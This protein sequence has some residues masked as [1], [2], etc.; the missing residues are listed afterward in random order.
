MCSMLLFSGKRHKDRLRRMKSWSP[1][2]LQHY[3]PRVYPYVY[4]QAQPV[5]CPC[6]EQPAPSFNPRSSLA[7]TDA[8]AGQRR[9]RFAVAVLWMDSPMIWRCIRFHS[10]A[11]P[12]AG[13]GA[14]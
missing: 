3:V 6:H 5:G 12:I 13:P 7:M 9:E 1:V 14:G 4:T 2:T 8:G 10:N 11:N